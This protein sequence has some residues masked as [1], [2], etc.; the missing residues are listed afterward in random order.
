MSAVRNL[1]FEGRGRVRNIVAQT[2][3]AWLKGID[4]Q[5]DLYYVM[6]RISRY[7][8]VRSAI[9]G[10]MLD[11]DIHVEFYERPLLDQLLEMAPKQSGRVDHV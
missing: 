10:W 8:A 2:A 6:R 5:P 3:W 4:P 1:V 9:A 7:P 11:G